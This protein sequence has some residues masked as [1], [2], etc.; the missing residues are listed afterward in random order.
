MVDLFRSV[1]VSWLRLAAIAA[2]GVVTAVSALSF[3]QPAQAATGFKR[4]AYFVGADGSLDFFGSNSD[5]VWSHAAPLTP[6]KSAPAG[7][8]VAAVRGA[9]GQLLAYYVGNDG[10]VYKSCGAVAGAYT[11]ITAAGFAPAGSIVSATLI[12]DTVHLTV[13]TSGGFSFADDPNDPPGCG[14]G[15]LPQWHPGPRPNWLVAGGYFTTVGYPDGEFGVFQA[16]L[17]GSVHAL[18][19]TAAGQWEDATLTGPGVAAPGGGVGATANPAAGAGI[20]G[21]AVSPNSSGPLPG[22]TSIFYAGSDGHVYVEHPAT[23]G[24][25]DQPVPLP[26]DPINPAKWAAQIGTLSAADGSTQIAYVSST[27]A[28]LVAG[29][30]GARWLP[31]KPVTGSGFGVAGGSVGVVGSA[32]DDL[33]VIYCGTPPGHIHIGP[34]GP[35]W[36]QAGAA[37]LTVPRTFSAVA[38]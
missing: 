32:A 11:A 25:S 28:L 2:A 12:V 19:W 13:G 20:R 22:V 8:S 24:L 26:W 9:S 15:K 34:N 6:A 33:D 37:G 35:S 21:A 7:S 30:V 10:A 36:I 16:G 4:G 27:G 1:R 3:A 5:G 31:P 29:G 18:W 23:N 14:T 38:Q 17:D